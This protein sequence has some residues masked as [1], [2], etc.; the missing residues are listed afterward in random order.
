ME[1]VRG[2]HHTRFYHAWAEAIDLEEQ[3]LILMPA[4]P[5]AFRQDDPLQGPSS[6]SQSEERKR[7]PNARGGDS[8]I[9]TKAPH[10]RAIESKSD[11]E[12]SQ[13]SSSEGHHSHIHG[14]TWKSMEQGREYLLEFDKLVISWV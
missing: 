7:Y 10:R 13:S 8:T 3:K 11:E 1:P 2:N 5:P 12:A 6:F 4:Y 9:L 14:E